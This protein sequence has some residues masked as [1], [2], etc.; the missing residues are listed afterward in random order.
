ML[1][2]KETA[3]IVAENAIVPAAIVG[4]TIYSTAKVQKDLTDKYKSASDALTTALV[5]GENK[6]RELKEAEKEVV[7]EKKSEEIQKKADEKAVQNTETK[8]LNSGTGPDV[9]IGID[10]LTGQSFLTTNAQ[11]EN[12]KIM[13]N[14]LLAEGFEVTLNDFLE[15]CSLEPYDLDTCELG[16]KYKWY[17]TEKNR[18]LSIVTDYHHDKYGRPAYLIL[19]PS[20]SRPEIS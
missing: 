6:V 20:G 2:F 1:P 7:G 15:K 4:V 18:E 5:L 13:V 11:I 3:V 10:V 12:A 16:D 14:R 19:Y 17:P 8:G 9:Y